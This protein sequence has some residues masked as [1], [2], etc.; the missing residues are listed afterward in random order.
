VKFKIAVLR[1]KVHYVL[2]EIQMSKAET[3]IVSTGCSDLQKHANHSQGDNTLR[4]ICSRTQSKIIANNHWKE[5]KI[6]DLTD[7]Q[8][9]N[10]FTCEIVVF[11][12]FLRHQA[13]VC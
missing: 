6:S 11:S 13:V 3:Y 4:C 7:R 10:L 2:C 9:I 12:K 8:K 5:S 1:D